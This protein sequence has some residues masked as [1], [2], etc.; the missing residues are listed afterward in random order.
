MI[1][2]LSMILPCWPSAAAGS[3]L[4]LH[5]GDTTVAF[6]F[7]H[8]QA[9]DLSGSITKLIQTFA[10][11]QKAERPKRWEMMEYRFKGKPSEQELEY[12]ELFCN[13]NQYTTAFDAK[14]LITMRTSEGVKVTT[15]GSLAAIKG[16]VDQYLESQA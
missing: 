3:S 7:K 6:P 13:P 16:D 4:T 11:K 1:N 10:A 5:I 12:L 14:V 15:E 2:G 9:K 8:E